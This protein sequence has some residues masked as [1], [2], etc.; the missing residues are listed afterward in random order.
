MKAHTL[1]MVMQLWNDETGERIEVSEDYD[2]FEMIQLR[3]VDADGHKSDEIRWNPSE[4]KQLI[5]AI[6]AVTAFVTNRKS[7]P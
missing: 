2:G 1:S 7:T 6:A 4:S 5:D 3:F